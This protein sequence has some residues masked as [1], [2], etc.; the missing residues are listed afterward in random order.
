M[1]R[2]KER[3]VL[4]PEHAWKLAAWIYADPNGTTTSFRSIVAAR[5][6]G[7]HLIGR[8]LMFAL[9]HAENLVFMSQSSLDEGTRKKLGRLRLV[10]RS[11]A[12][13]QKD[14]DESD[15]TTGFRQGLEG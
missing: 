13:I 1:S 14:G 3:V 15:H 2:F 4:L 9:C 7:A 5:A 12:S 6:P 8:D 11:G 10:R